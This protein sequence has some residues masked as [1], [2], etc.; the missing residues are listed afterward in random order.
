MRRLRSRSSKLGCELPL[1]AEPASLERD[2]A[3]EHPQVLEVDL[4]ASRSEHAR[5]V[6]RR[7]NGR[8]DSLAERLTGR[9]AAE[10]VVARARSRG[11]LR[12]SRAKPGRT[13]VASGGG[14]IN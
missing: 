7:G 4:A 8:A 6:T 12:S 5:K 3:P 11:G 2:N 10:V 14:E 9:I 1:P 13:S